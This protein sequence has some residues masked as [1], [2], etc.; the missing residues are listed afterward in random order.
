MQRTWPGRC[1]SRPKGG[2]W[3]MR[4]SCGNSSSRS[5]RTSATWRT[6]RKARPCPRIGRPTSTRASAGSAGSMG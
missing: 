3:R 1:G 5:P 6:L 2:W 4:R